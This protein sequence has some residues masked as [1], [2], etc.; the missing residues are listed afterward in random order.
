MTI[1]VSTLNNGVLPP[2]YKIHSQ[3]Q[4][5]KKWHKNGFKT[6]NYSQKRDAF[7]V[8]NS[9]TI[10]EQTFQLLESGHLIRS[11]SVI[12]AIPMKTLSQNAV[13]GLMIAA[14][15]LQ[16]RRQK[17]ATKADVLQI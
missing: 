5:F 12:S 2:H 14:L 7:T 9:S 1:L 16:Q 6:A 10:G 3:W 4:L 8:N 11:L 13:R 15:G 17:A